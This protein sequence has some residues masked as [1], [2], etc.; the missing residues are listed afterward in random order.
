MWTA[1]WALNTL[2][3]KGKASDW[4]V[5]MLGQ[6]VGGYTN[7][8]HGMTLSAV[9]LAYY[10][11][12]LTYGLAKFVRFAKNVWNV[13]PTGKTDEQV[14]EEGLAAME[15][16]MKEIGV[17]MHLSEFGVTEDNLESIADLTLPMNGGY[18]VLDRN[19]IIEI[20]RKSL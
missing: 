10:H 8:T 7:A 3:A 2:V 4:M 17:V 6:A 20:F 16:W 5:H 1:T 9:S 11:Y 12:I 14:A 13:D 15:A 18:K 19:E